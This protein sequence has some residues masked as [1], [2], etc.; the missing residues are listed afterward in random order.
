MKLSVSLPDDDV[1]YVDEY[2]RRV[3]APSRSSVL[4]RAIELLRMSEMEDAYEAAW[5][6]WEAGDDAR[7][8]EKTAADGISDAPR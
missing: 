2:A 7:L 1:T 6:E 3:G 4:H 5:D 8:W